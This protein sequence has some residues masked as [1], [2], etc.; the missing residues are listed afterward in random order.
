MASYEHSLR[1]LELANQRTAKKPVRRLVALLFGPRL[2]IR[3]IHCPLFALVLTNDA[4][5]LA[6]RLSQDGKEEEGGGDGGAGH[7]HGHGAGGRG[8]GEKDDTVHSQAMSRSLKIM[9]RMV[10]QNAE[11][12]TARR[13]G[14]RLVA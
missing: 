9:E 13:R 14:A 5:S 1:E 4:R 8:A 6:G 10:N 2:G 11:V 3:V 12:R 7:G